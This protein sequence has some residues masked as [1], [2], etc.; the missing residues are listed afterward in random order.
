MEDSDDKKG[1]GVCTGCFV[2]ST[3][4]GWQQGEENRR[5]LKKKKGKAE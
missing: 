5:L 4:V 2:L 1:C 3:N